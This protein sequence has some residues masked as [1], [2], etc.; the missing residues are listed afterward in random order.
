M[1]TVFTGLVTFFIAS[2]GNA[3]GDTDGAFDGAAGDFAGAAGDLTGA[4]G[5][6][7]GIAPGK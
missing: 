6:V 7:F 2:L 5:R 1:L 3:A 4:A